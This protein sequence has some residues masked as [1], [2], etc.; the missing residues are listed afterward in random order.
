MATVTAR[1]PDDKKK[2]AMC[3][4]KKLGIPLWSL[5]NVWINDFLRNQTIH[6]SL[7]DTDDNF[8]EWMDMVE[9]DDTM[10]SFSK[11]LKNLIAKRDTNG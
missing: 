5:I 7:D 2:A 6:V 11:E 8:Y 1:V 3:L 4:A 10:K 9:V